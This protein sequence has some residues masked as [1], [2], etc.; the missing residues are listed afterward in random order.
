MA[1]GWEDLGL[2]DN[3]FAST[4]P[5]LAGEDN[6]IWADMEEIHDKIRGRIRHSV[7]TSPYTLVLNW[8]PWGGGK[9]HAANY[10]SQ[11]RVLSQI[12]EESG[13]SVPLSVVIN[14]PRGSNSIVKDI[15]NNIVGFIGVE[16]ISNDLRHVRGEIGDD[17]FKKLVGNFMSD[18]DLRDAILKLSKY[19]TSGDLFDNTGGISNT[20]RRYFNGETTKTDL[21]DLKIGRNITNSNDYIRILTSI[22]NIVTYENDGDLPLYSE[23]IIWIDE[24]EE[25]KSLPGKQQNVL[26]GMIRDLTDY[27]P[28]DISIFLNFSSAPGGGYEDLGAFLGGAVWDRVREE[29]EFTSLNRESFRQFIQDILNSENYR[30]EDSSFEGIEPLTGEAADSL[31][32]LLRPSVSPRRINEIMSLVFEQFKNNT[33]ENDEPYLIDDEFIDSIEED[34]VPIAE[35]GRYQAM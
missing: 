24:M 2:E 15:Y 22:I 17:S 26:S 16:N 35:R 14:V 6:I 1:I 33:E 27:I 9:T 21:E 13:A 10:F 3:P 18:S 20:L 12:S 8:G 29:N 34:L 28:K 11:D 23:F 19:K 7:D 32:E 4:P 5:T 30:P 31:F 25:I